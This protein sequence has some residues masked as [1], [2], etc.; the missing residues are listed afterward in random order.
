MTNKAKKKLKSMNFLT[1]QRVRKI[2]K[3][4]EKKDE[5]ISTINRGSL[6]PQYI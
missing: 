6:R 4:I 5:N 3:T 2:I 1:Q